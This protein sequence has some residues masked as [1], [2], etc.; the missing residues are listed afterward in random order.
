MTLKTEM[1]PHQ[2]EAFSKM[3]RNKVGAIFMEMGTGKSLVAINLIAFYRNR[4]VN[5]CIWV[6]PVNTI[7]T[8]VSEINKHSNGLNVYAFSQKTKTP[9]PADV[10]VVGCE[11]L[12]Q[13]DRLFLAFEALVDDALVILDESHNFRTPHA[14]R[15]KRMLALSTRMA[16]RY[17]M[18]GTPISR[19]I[20]D[21]Y[22][23]VTFLSKKILGYSSY[24]AFTHYHL[25][26]D[27]IE[28][29]RIL[30]RYFKEYISTKM[31]P[32]TYQVTKADCMSL[33]PKSYT[34]YSF[35]LSRKQSAVYKE[36]KER[37]LTVD[38]LRDVSSSIA[39][40]R[41]FGA[42]QRVCC[43]FNPI[44]DNTSFYEDAKDNPRIDTLLSIIESI[45][46]HAKVLI[47]AK[48]TSDIEAIKAVLP[49][50]AVVYGDVVESDRE[51]E[52]DRFRTSERFLVMNPATGGVGLT[53]N[54]AS[55]VIFYSQTFKYIDRIQA[56]DRCHRIGQTKNVHY[57][58]IEAN[59]K[60]EEVIC[61]NLDR[62]EDAAASFKKQIDA[63]KKATNKKDAA[64][65]LARLTNGL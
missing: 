8:I 27:P 61:R 37:M 43:G 48:Y 36:V 3:A 9:P 35:E 54:E 26:V 24:G 15:T 50:A 53:L 60:I 19:G 1:L 58:T 7:Q 10:Y 2:A 14:T 6:C 38:Y 47:W 16:A 40:Y 44:D 13:S 31:A 46:E 63:I 29:G 52:I 28:R 23:P 21:L 34:T 4:G 32:Y 64:T 5:R 56:E 59:A 55:Y 22:A 57:I 20:E 18:T 49:S 41:L 11:S 25:K 65:M 39:I 42:L 62:K 45:P 33:P 17:I 51:T 12:S 30:R